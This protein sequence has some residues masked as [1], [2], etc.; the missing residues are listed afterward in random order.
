MT[1]IDTRVA[2]TFLQNFTFVFGDMRKFGKGC[3]ILK[4]VQCCKKSISGTE[5]ADII[6]ASSRNV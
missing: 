6:F 1:A 2:W 3:E 4:K 5:H